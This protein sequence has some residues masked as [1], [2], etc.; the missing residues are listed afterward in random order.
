MIVHGRHS[1]VY[2]EGRIGLNEITMKTL[3]VFLLLA[4]SCLAQDEAAHEELRKTRSEIIA[5]IESRDQARILAKLAP[6]VVVTW[7]D[8]SVCHGKEELKA[9][10]DRIGKNAFVA[11][12]V[13]H[14]PDRLSVLHGGDTALATGRVVAEYHLLGKAFEFQSRWTATLVRKDGQWLIAAYHVSLNALDNPILSAAK[15][16]AWIA[17]G[18]G[19]LIGILVTFVVAKLRRKP[20]S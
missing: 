19:L 15:S 17:A 14:E 18:L 10:Y 12:K 13:P 11:F 6:D 7:Q 5:A 3:A 1:V 8:G 2:P 20:V 9:Y 16:A 4:A